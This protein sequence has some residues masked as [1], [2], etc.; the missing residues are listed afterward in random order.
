M[1]VFSTPEDSWTHAALGCQHFPA[2]LDMLRTMLERVVNG[3][4]FCDMRAAD[5]KM[6]LVLSMRNFNR[7]HPLV[8]Q[9]DPSDESFDV[10]AGEHIGLVSWTRF[11]PHEK[12]HLSEYVQC[13]MERLGYQLKVYGVMDG[14]KLVPYQCAVVRQEWDELR[15]AFYKAFKVQK[16]AYRHGNGGSKT[17]NLTEDSLPH[18]LPGVHQ[19]ELQAPPKLFN[20]TVRKTFVELEEGSPQG[21]TRL[22]RSLST[23]AVMTC[24]V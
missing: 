1:F 6:Y 10:S 23:G 15:T 5:A 3:P 9:R 19:G 21:S 24:F 17:P 20:T 14:R 16:A 18:F 2:F 4:G 8:P 12:F 13:F 11:K 22:K 7:G